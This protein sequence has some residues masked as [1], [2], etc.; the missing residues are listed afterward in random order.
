[1][2]ELVVF[3][4]AKG[5]HEA[6]GA[7][8]RIPGHGQPV[9][10]VIADQL[11]NASWPKFLHPYPLSEKYFLVSA[12]L[13][14]A[15]DWGIYLADIFDNLVLLHRTPGSALLEPLPLRS[16]PPPPVIPDKVDLAQSEATVFVQDIYAGPGLAGVPRG[17][18]KQL[19]ILEY[20]YAYPQMGGHINIGIDGPWDVH[21]ILGTV[22]VN[23]DGSAGFRVPANRPLALQPLDAQGKALQVMRSWFT[24]MPGEHLSCVG[25]HERQNS[26]GTPRPTMAATQPPAPI[27][28]WYGPPRGFSFAREVQPVLDRH[29][30]GCHN[31]SPR[32]PGETIPD[33]RGDQPEVVLQT[34]KANNKKN[35]G[36]FEFDAAYVALHPFVRR[37][38][39]ES[40]YHLQV[41]GE[42]HADTSELVQLLQAGHHGVQLDPEAWDRLITWIDLNVPD[43]GTWSEHRKIA[44]NFQQRRQALLAKYAGRTNDPET[45]PTPAPE[46]RPALPSPAATASVSAAAAGLTAQDWPFATAV[47]KRRQADAG[48]PATLKLPL[49]ETVAMEF[50]LVPA[51]QFVMGDTNRARGG[52]RPTVARVEKRF[53]LGTFEVS[54]QQFGAFDAAHDSGYISEF[55]KDQSVRGQPAN[56]PPQPVIRVSWQEAMAFCQWLTQKTGR[57][58]TLPT[59]TQWEWACRAGT[60]TPW[61]FGVDGNDFSRFANLADQRLLQ[62]CRGNS[63]KWIPAVT[64]VNDGAVVTTTVGHYQPNAWDL[65]DMLGNAAE[66]TLTEDAGRKVARGGSFY[67]RPQRATA[68]CRVSYPDWQKVFNVGFRVVCEEKTLLAQAAVRK[69]P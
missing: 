5:R 45:Y 13:A 62:L 20:H 24:A 63:P 38:G 15:A 59:E 22:P 51:G 32:Q 12:K 7:V 44:G 65:R 23:A 56:L 43:H 37:P 36:G 35:A 16:T 4:P 8:Q 61:N 19:R 2:G 48:M 25:C 11:V 68:S 67:D 29:C 10:P 47:A 53:Y 9:A 31:G 64:N 58:C 50:T 66:W 18:V 34:R 39:P 33:L 40:D 54:N 1:M 6:G 69:G 17:A 27:A 30:V 14:P 46:R 41:P 49:S 21:R 28:E 60:A 52:S 3:D 55:N 57:R 42:W 26:T